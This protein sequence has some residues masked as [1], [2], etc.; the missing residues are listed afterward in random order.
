MN[1]ND[2]IGRLMFTSWA[3]VVVILAVTPSDSIPELSTLYGGKILTSLLAMACL[4][5]VS[6][7]VINDFMPPRYVFRSAVK[8][9]TWAYIL[10]SFVFT[11][12]LFVVARS[13]GFIEG[14]TIALYTTMVV[15]GLLLSFRN[16]FCLRGKK[17]AT[18]H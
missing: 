14:G 12:H 16:I 11:A 18:V 6:D 13:I 9:R 1:H 15:F 17:R 2:F 3:V 7:L 4:F 8:W 5:L 10:S